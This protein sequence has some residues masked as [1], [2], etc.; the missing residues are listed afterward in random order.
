MF[1]GK[2]SPQIAAQLRSARRHLKAFM[3]RGFELVYDNYNALAFGFSPSSRPSDAVLSIVGYPRWI[4]LFFLKG[5]ELPDPR[6]LLEGSG[7]RVRSIRLSAAKDILSAPVA[8]LIRTALARASPPFAA[9]PRMSTVIRS[10]S[11]KQ[12]PRRPG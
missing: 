7:S 12:R 6:G 9:A 8:D 1:L 4:T 5:V 10:V 3:P 11:K 2:Y